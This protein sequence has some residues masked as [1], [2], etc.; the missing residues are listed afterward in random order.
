[1]TINFYFL[2]PELV[3]SIGRILFIFGIWVVSPIDSK[4]MLQSHNGNDRFL[5]VTITSNKSWIEFSFSEGVF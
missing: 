2:Y 1:M 3:K 4:K 5:C